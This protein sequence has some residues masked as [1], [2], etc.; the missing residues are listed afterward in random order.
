VADSA[1]NRHLRRTYAA[2]NNNYKKLWENEAEVPGWPSMS[3]QPLRFQP[4]T[5]VDTAGHA[6]V[7]PPQNS[8]SGPAGGYSSYPQNEVPVQNGSRRSIQWAVPGLLGLNLEKRSVP[9]RTSGDS[10]YFRAQFGAAA[11]Q[12]AEGTFACCKNGTTNARASGGRMQWEKTV[13]GNYNEREAGRSDKN[14]RSVGGV[15]F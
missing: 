8:V 14:Y 12:W 2:E 1:I 15:L 13:G 7:R 6:G 3:A 4:A 5:A 10:Y 9:Q 11:I